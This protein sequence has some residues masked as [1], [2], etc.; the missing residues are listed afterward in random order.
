[1]IDLKTRMQDF[2][3]FAVEHKSAL[4]YSSFIPFSKFSRQLRPVV[5]L[6]FAP[7][8]ARYNF[9]TSHRTSDDRTRLW[10]CLF[11]RKSTF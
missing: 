9:S 1:M 8:S 11:I 3:I 7:E 4:E 10:R 6:L 5:E 2:A